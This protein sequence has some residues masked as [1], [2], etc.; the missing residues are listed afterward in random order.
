MA[1]R[2]GRRFK[3]ASEVIQNLYDGIDVNAPDEYGFTFLMNAIEYQQIELVSLLLRCGANPNLGYGAEDHGRPLFDAVEK[4]QTEIIRLLLRFGANLN[5]LESKTES[6]RLAFARSDINTIAY[7]LDR[8]LDPNLKLTDR[9]YSET[10]IITAVRNRLDPLVHKLLEYELFLDE[11]DYDGKTCLHYAVLNENLLIVQKLLVAGANPNIYDDD[12]VYILATAIQTR[13]EDIIFM[14]INHG[15]DMEK[16]HVDRQWANVLQDRQ[17]T[18]CG[19]WLVCAY[20]M[21]FHVLSK[22]E[23]AAKIEKLALCTNQLGLFYKL[24]KKGA[25][26]NKHN[27]L[28]ESIL[29]S[30]IECLL[31]RRYD[32]ATTHL[33]MRN[34]LE[35]G[36][37][38]TSMRTFPYIPSTVYQV[39]SRAILQLLIDHGLLMMIRDGN[40]TS[41]LPIHQALHNTDL[42]LITYL[43]RNLHVDTEIC[44]HQGRTAVMYAAALDQ[45]PQM[46]LLK[47][48][49]ANMNHTC[50]NGH[51]LL[52]HSVQP[53]YIGD[54]FEWLINQ[55]DLGTILDVLDCEAVVETPIYAQYIIKHVSLGYAGTDYDYIDNRIEISTDENVEFHKQCKEEIELLHKTLVGGTKLSILITLEKD[56]K[57]GRNRW[58]RAYTASEEFANKFPIFY[59]ELKE[60]FDEAAAVQNLIYK[61]CSKMCTKLFQV[62]YSANIV[63]LDT[64]SS[65]LDMDDFENLCRL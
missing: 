57:V 36:A 53:D 8:G 4:G 58:M 11:K 35:G 41:S 62:D 5:L 49:G 37:T 25:D 3:T 63:I 17:N 30:C 38:V 48:L 6:V 26:V 56:S 29:D 15:A 59:K 18:T 47:E 31:T 7:L 13:N 27:N 21:M 12:G 44:D 42:E 55:T 60:K 1:A 50:Q 24:I 51:S 20:D 45:V 40:N 9:R 52:Q 34:L 61:A 19:D 39:A 14:L 16:I 23:P 22:R 2:H 46:L 28:R 64:I 65:Y 54:A 10:L 43:V 33:L 32:K